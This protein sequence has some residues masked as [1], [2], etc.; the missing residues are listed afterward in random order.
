MERL[1]AKFGHLSWTQEAVNYKIATA[2]VYWCPLPN[3]FL[4]SYQNNRLS[5]FCP[6]LP[7]RSY[8]FPRVC[9]T[10]IKLQYHNTINH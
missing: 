8:A 1:S 6:Y 2:S 5:F 7:Y 9:T 10:S 4:V 3:Y